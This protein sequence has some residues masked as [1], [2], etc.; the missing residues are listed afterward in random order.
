MVDLSFLDAKSKYVVSQGLDELARGE[1][2]PPDKRILCLVED[3]RWLVRHSAIGALAKCRDPRAEAALLN[4]AK[5]T[6][7]AFDLAY[8]NSALAAI[9]GP[10][11]LPYLEQASRHAKQD[12]VCSALNAIQKI[13]GARFVS[14]YVERLVE[15]PAVVKWYAM[16]ALQTHGDA[17]FV[18]PVANRVVAILK[19]K[20]KI[21]QLPRSELMEALTYLAKH[22]S[23]PE[24]ADVFDKL[25][26][27]RLD[28]LFPTERKQLN[29]LLPE[30]NAA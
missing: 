22:R 9:G 6:D 29:E 8:I 30:G 1:T 23:L 19:R 5:R 11:S 15:G 28:R 12:V 13:A 21:E 10:Q 18:R 26:P 17:R 25:L 24:A 2:V 16:A 20:R 27:K 4:R 14:L 3:D 7:D